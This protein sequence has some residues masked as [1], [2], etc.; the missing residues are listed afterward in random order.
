MRV[1]K[2]LSERHENRIRMNQTQRLM[3]RESGG[4]ELNRDRKIEFE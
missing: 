1:R 2:I 3:V 4:E